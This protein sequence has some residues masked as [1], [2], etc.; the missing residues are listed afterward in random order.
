[1]PTL[2]LQKMTYAVPATT[3]NPRIGSRPFLAGGI[4]AWSK[5]PQTHDEAIARWFVEKRVFS[6]TI[7][8]RSKTK[9]LNAMEKNGTGP[10]RG[11]FMEAPLM[12]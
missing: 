1:M 11:S 4:K 9:I 3:A 10:S 7:A 8:G 12:A 5:A 6:K 2:H